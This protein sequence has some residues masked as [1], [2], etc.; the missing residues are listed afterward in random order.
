MNEIVRAWVE[1]WVVSRGAAPPVPEP[2]GVTIDVGRPGHVHRHVF[3][4]VGADVE[5][6]V[7]RKVAE[8]VTGAGVWLK[9]FH[10]P[11]TVGS[12]L[13]PDWWID[14]EPGCLM[15][16][17]LPPARRPAPPA[18]YTT[19]TWT[20]SG[21]TRALV[22]ASDGSFAAGG[23]IAV[24]GTTAVFDQIETSPAHRRRGLGTTV[25]RTLHSAATAQGAHTG[26][27]AGTPAGHALYTTLGWRTEAT[28]TSARFG[29]REAG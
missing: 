11:E 6:A 12:W 10:D 16:T 22:A 26:V 3:G 2:W 23:Q 21:V 7:V 20:R 15:T 17:P 25:M 19:R 28:L 1:G 24:T 8:G 18:G 4:A 14:P 27:L 29:G 9:V 5:E 13:G